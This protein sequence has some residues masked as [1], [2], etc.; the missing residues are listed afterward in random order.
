MSEVVQLCNLA[1]NANALGVESKA[2]QYLREIVAISGGKYEHHAALYLLWN[3]AGLAVLRGEWV[4]ALRLGGAATS[5]Q[6]KH[7]LFDAVDARFNA[8]SMA[9]AR[10]AIAADPADAAFA[11]GRALG[12]DTAIRE[13]EA[14]LGAL[15]V[16]GRKGR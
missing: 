10:E 11:A 4:Q 1:R 3:C 2:V 16:D 12:S 5:L 14:W 13:A 15:A 7:N 8:R 9:T 6:E